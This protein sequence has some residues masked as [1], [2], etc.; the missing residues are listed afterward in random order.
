[1]KTLQLFY[2]C[3]LEI[4]KQERYQDK[5]L[6]D[7][8]IFRAI[9]A[10]FPSLE[11]LGFNRGIMNKAISS[12]EGSGLDDY[13]A[14]NRTGRFRRQAKGID[15]YGNP[16]R[17]IWGYFVTTPGGLVARPPDG[18][19]N[20]LSLLQDESISDRYSVARGLSEVIDLTNEI[21]VQ[22]KAKRRAEAEATAAEGN[23]KAKSSVSIA[24]AAAAGSASAKIVVQS[25]WDSP[26]AKKLFL[27]TSTDE[28]DVVDILQQRIERLQQVNRSPDGWRDL[29][30]KH[31]VD[32]LCSPY[33]IFIIR[34]RCSILCLAY[35]VALEE[36]NSARWIEDC[37]AQAI[38][39]SSRMGIEAAATTER[40]VADW[41]ILLR[42]NCEHFPLPD[43]KIRKQKK[44]LPDLL[45]YFREEI[46][47]P[48][49]S[50][51]ISNLADLTVEL[52][53][54]E[55]VTRIIPKCIL[56]ESQQDNDDEDE[57][58]THHNET[59]EMFE[60]NNDENQMP[61][62]IKD[63]ILMAYNDKPISMSTAWRW[64]KRLGFN[65][66]SR[67]KSFFV[68]G[69]ER[70]DVVFYRNEFCTNYLSKLEPRTRRWIQVTKETVE[71]WKL[72]KRIPNDESAATRGYT[73][74][75][76]TSGEDMIEFHVDDFDFLH[77]EADEM[78]FGAAGGNLSIRKPPNTKPLMIFGQDES[79]FN[80]FL[81]KSRFWR[82]PSGQHPGFVNSVVSA[83][84][85]NDAVAKN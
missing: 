50:Y 22:T 30:D 56:L 8:T 41:N 80:Q 77:S 15:I 43:P 26:E 6:S 62:T 17:N 85:E 3:W 47:V 27:G 53:R 20:F 65:H 9:K 76:Q 72:E 10:Q 82:G 23:K 18:K 21:Q 42:A 16:K 71:R 58:T 25:Y 37:C 52:A 75:D 74:R 79:V 35:T 45:E 51:C 1:M 68:D 2:E 29:V 48:W 19:R 33:D 4:A 24:A 11:A 78:G 69:H 84:I 12:Y 57:T 31:D 81:L 40:T 39:D 44:P 60:N 38:Y 36:M 7:E 49:V 66:C 13:T 73:Y 59:A 63:S 46:T 70:P 34:Q 55:L 67:R 14:S 28:R 5:W 32:N 64:L 83:A 54:N 61:K